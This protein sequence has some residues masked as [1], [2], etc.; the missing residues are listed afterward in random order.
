MVDW[1][2]EVL[3]KARKLSNNMFVDYPDAGNRVAASLTVFL[4]SDGLPGFPTTLTQ[5]N[6]AYWEDVYRR[7]EHVFLA[8]MAM[9]LC[10][11]AAAEAGCERM[12]REMGIAMADTNTRESPEVAFSSIVLKQDV[13]SI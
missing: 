4:S 12:F 6:V 8:E 2:T 7:S 5:N 1:K 13:S 11:C 9:S 10:V 3:E